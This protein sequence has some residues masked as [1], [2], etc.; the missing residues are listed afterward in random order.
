[1]TWHT[2]LNKALITVRVGIDSPPGEP[3]PD[4]YIGYVMKGLVPEAE[5][6]ET[7]SRFFGAWEWHFEVEESAWE[8]HLPTLKARLESLYEGPENVRGEAWGRIK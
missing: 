8:R 7:V 6:G 1:M 4:A 2:I 5:I 3:R